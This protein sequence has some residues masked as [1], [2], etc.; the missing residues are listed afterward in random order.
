MLVARGVV[1]GTHGTEGKTISLDVTTADA[2]LED[3]FRLAVNSDRDSIY[4]ET[5]CKEVTS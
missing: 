5:F 2:R 1:A 3:L 4:G